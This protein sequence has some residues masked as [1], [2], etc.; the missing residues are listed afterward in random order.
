MTNVPEPSGKIRRAYAQ[1][2]RDAL[3]EVRDPPFQT[4]NNY[5]VVQAYW[6]GWHRTTEN[7]KITKIHVA[8]LKKKPR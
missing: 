5:E 7:I 4:E 3:R 1:G 8:K 2:R 6:E